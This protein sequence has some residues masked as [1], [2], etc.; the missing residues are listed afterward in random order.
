MKTIKKILLCV[1]IV[2][3]LLMPSYLSA[4]VTDRVV[5]IVNGDII[6]LYE[7]NTSIRN[8]TGMDLRELRQKDKKNFDKVRQTV[9]N[10]MINELIANQHAN[11]LGIRVA[12]S[13]VEEAIE[14]VKKDNQLSHEDLIFSL[15]KEGITFNDYKERIKKEI[16]RARLVNHEVKSKIVVTEAEMKEYYNKHF[17]EFIE[18]GKVLLARIFLPIKSPTDDD[19]VAKVKALG[20]DI[21]RRL[22]NG[23]SFF[24]LAITYSKGPAAEEGGR[25]GWIKMNNID[26]ALR[27][28]V[29]RLSPGKHSGLDDVGSG[30][31]I[32]KLLD[33]K[34]GNVKT[35]KELRG[36][37]HARLFKEKVEEKYAVWLK[38]LRDESYIKVM[39]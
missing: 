39:F 16:E 38:Q 26:H 25:L 27:Q 14:R 22:D 31:Q 7:L 19:E 13:D 35:F 8:L 28:T 11:K 6:T 5:A 20:D 3:V 32:L 1:W 36:A 34:G 21:L 33:K 9:L 15:K 37:I 24:D 23:E 2:C 17:K 12:E 18:E 30:F 10:S 4:E 29:E